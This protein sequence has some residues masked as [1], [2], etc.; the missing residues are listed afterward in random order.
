[1]MSLTKMIAAFFLLFISQL[2]SAE[3][4]ETEAASQVVQGFQSELLNIMQQ[5]DKLNF[6]QRFEQLKP[7][8]IKTHDLAKI[9]RII[10]SKEWQNL[11][12]E[13]KEEL[14]QKFS[15]L[16]IASYAHYFKSFSGENF[17]VEL[18]KQLSPGQIYVHTFLVLPDDKNVSMD[19]L[20]KKTGDDWRIIN[21][22]T[23]GVSDLALKRSEYVAVIQKSGFDALISEISA[24]IEK[25]SQ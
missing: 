15:T 19:Y 17:K 12:T 18:V 9:T 11:S 23:N 2:V 10:V 7:V 14:I 13:Q 21:I 25:F 8:V 6:E 3:V 4:D 24:K 22:I 1:M 16:S 20:L 5:G